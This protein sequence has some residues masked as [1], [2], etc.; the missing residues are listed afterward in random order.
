ML[1]GLRGEA[2]KARLQLLEQLHDAGVPLEELTRAVEEDRLALVPVELVLGSEGK[3]TAAEVGGTPWEARR[4]V[5][6][7]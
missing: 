2:R 6:S 3:Y 5:T 1:R 4:K 7:C